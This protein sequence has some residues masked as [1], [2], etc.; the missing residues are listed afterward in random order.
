VE[1][2]LPA[3]SKSVGYSNHRFSSASKKNGSRK[4]FFFA[5]AAA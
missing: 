1:S 4:L 2:P 5:A 3:E